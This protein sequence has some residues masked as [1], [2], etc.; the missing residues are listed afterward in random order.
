[1]PE[2]TLKQQIEREFASIDYTLARAKLALEQDDLE[3]FRWFMKA[4]DQ[5]FDQ[6]KELQAQLELQERIKNFAD[7]MQS[8]GIQ[9]HHLIYHF[10]TKK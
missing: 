3:S 5:S 8:K 1:M 6:V 4:T 7:E 9:V 10:E 2:Y